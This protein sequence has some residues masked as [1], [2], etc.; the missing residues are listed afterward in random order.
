MSSVSTKT[1]ILLIALM[2]AATSGAQAQIS[3]TLR[4]R[5]I[6]AEAQGQMVIIDLL[7]D[8]GERWHLHASIFIKANYPVV[9]GGYLLANPEKLVGK[10]VVVVTY[11]LESPTQAG[12]RKIFLEKPG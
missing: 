4:G 6:Q 9:D 11:A 5:V 12:I 2:A 10:R 3:E 7:T 8:S 1:L